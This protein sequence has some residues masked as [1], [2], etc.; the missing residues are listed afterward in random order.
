MSIRINSQRPDLSNLCKQREVKIYF[1]P[2]NYNCASASL[3]MLIILY[4]RLFAEMVAKFQCTVIIS[5]HVNTLCR[6]KQPFYIKGLE[7]KEKN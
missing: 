2:A 5:R 1:V 7:N 6:L 3:L 4:L